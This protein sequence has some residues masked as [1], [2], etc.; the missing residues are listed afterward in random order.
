LTNQHPGI[1]Q[2]QARPSRLTSISFNVPSNQTF[3]TNTITITNS[4]PSTCHTLYSR[5]RPRKAPHHPT[6][7]RIRS[8]RSSSRRRVAQT[9]TAPHSSH[10]ARRKSRH[11]WPL[12]AGI[13]AQVDALPPLLSGPSSSLQ[14]RI[15]QTYTGGCCC[16]V[17]SEMR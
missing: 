9:T 6:L 2:C 14:L 13:P 5:P 3:F 16:I 10:T 17:T 12:S 7:L 4:S 8:M 15:N 11:L 1:P